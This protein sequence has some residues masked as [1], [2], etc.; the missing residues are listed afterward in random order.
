MATDGA[1]GL[2]I[3][4]DYGIISAMVLVDGQRRII[5]ETDQSVG[6]PTCCVV[7]SGEP[8]SSSDLSTAV[9]AGN[10]TVHGCLASNPPPT[11]RAVPGPRAGSGPCR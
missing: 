4:P 8:L 10:G 5:V 7:V 6:C 11:S 3:L 2:L 9:T 1:T